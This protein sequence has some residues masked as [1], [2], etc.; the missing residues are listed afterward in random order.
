MIVLLFRLLIFIAIILLLFTAYKYVINPK[1]KLEVAS[2]KKDFFLLD[3][4]ENIKKNF[5]MTY[6]GFLFE[7]EKYLGTTEHSF[8]VVNI[9]I[10][11]HHP[12][13]LKGLERD[14]LHF[15]EKEVLIRYPFAEVEWKHPMDKLLLNK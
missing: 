8:D 6:K 3:D 15:M 1:R 11:A 12:A 7:G 10:H 5:L 2:E 4:S 14:D 13:E 9:S